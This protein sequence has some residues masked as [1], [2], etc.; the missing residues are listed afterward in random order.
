MKKKK[1]SFTLLKALDFLDETTYSRGYPDD[2]SGV[3]GDDDRPPGNIVYG[4]KYKKTPYF[5]KLTTFQKSY[6]V[7]L[8]DWTWDEF[9]N[10]VGME[11][12]RNYSNT[13]FSMEDL[14]PEETWKRMM[15]RF[16]YVSPEDA[17]KGFI[18]AG[19][20]WRKGG[21]DQAGVDKK[22][23]ADVK[24]NKRKEFKDAEVVKESLEDRIRDI[25]L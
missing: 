8:G 16:K 3:A 15:S 25:I 22:A 2:G 7:D 5:N 19:Q 4:E 10:S 14:F 18:D 6:E 9:E 23:H 24:I 1:R 13:I 11:D 17:T 21:R 20:P 12:L